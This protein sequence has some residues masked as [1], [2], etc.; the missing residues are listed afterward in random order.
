GLGL[1]E[2]RWDSD[3]HRIRESNPH[4][5]LVVESGRLEI[6]EKDGEREVGLGTDYNEDTYYDTKDYSLLGNDMS[7]RARIRRDDPNPDPSGVRRVLIQSK[8]GSEVDE[9]GMKAADKAD[10]RK[11]RPTESDI[12]GLDES[13]RSGLSSWDYGSPKP[14]EAMGIVYNAL[15][16]KDALPDIGDQQDV[17]LL[18]EKAHIRSTRSRFHFNEPSRSSTVDFFRQTGEPKIRETLD[19]LKAGGMT[20]PDAEKLQ[21][22]GE[23]LLDKSAFVERCKDK[24]IALDPS[25]EQSGINADTIKRLWPDNSVTSNKLETAKR[26]VVANEIK[27]AYDEFSALMDDNRREIAGSRSPEA[28][29]MG[30]DKELMG[31]MREKY[32]EMKKYQ[33][34]GPFLKKY[35]EIVAGPNKDSFVQEFGK[36]AAD[37]GEDGLQ[38]AG[39]KDAALRGLRSH[40]VNEHLDIMHR[41]IEAAGTSAQTLSFD[42]MRKSYANNDRNYGNFLIDTFDVSEFYT[43]DA[44]NK[45]SPE[46]RA[47]AKEVDPKNMF[48]ATVVNEVQIEL[49]YEK[50]FVEA[51]DKAQAALD[52]ARGGLFMDYAIENGLAQSSDA[53]STFETLLSNT[54]KK[55]ESERKSFFAA[56][57]D[58]A[59]ARGSALTF[60]AEN[61]KSLDEGDFS[62]FNRNQSTSNHTQLLEDLRM[63]QFVWGELRNAQE[64]IADLRG[65]RVTR[66]ADRAGFNTK[67]INS[68]MSK[69]DMALTLLRDGHL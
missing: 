23:S 59:Q 14:I 38:K 37:Q 13:V 26:D 32:P 4:V 65:D 1:D 28:R 60:D 6:D 42:N 64:F 52:K 9:S 5:S 25:L 21:K 54:L 57:N 53:S 12:N 55:P 45:L 67:W 18:E 34:V 27:A 16:D 46:E 49:G 56:L 17:L 33:T 35:D 44:W 7:V 51:M 50:P 31:F 40:L 61:T 3:A 41:Q 36:F 19:L 43:T 11:D 62:S 30:L 15:K 66:E 68:E 22:L 29:G 20:G 69:G 58:F 10:I 2:M 47:G 8:V 63:T 48:H 24:L 39:D